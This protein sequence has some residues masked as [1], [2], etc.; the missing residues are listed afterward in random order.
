MTERENYQ[1]SGIRENSAEMFRAGA[2]RPLGKYG[3]DCG[4][5]QA[6][7]QKKKQVRIIPD[8]GLLSE[9]GLSPSTVWQTAGAFIPG[10]KILLCFLNRIPKP[11]EKVLSQLE[12]LQQRPAG[13]RKANM[14]YDLELDEYAENLISETF[15]S[16]SSEQRLDLAALLTNKSFIHRSLS[17][18]PGSIK[19]LNQVIEIYES[20][21]METNPPD[22]RQ[23]LAGRSGVKESCTTKS[24]ITPRQQDLYK[25]AVAIYEELIR[26]DRDQ[27][28][29]PALARTWT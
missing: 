6:I 24:E 27:A 15:K 10:G 25:K 5:A 23:N 18:F 19:V 20:L 22:I 29:I 14:L 3:G 11:S 9:D 1:Q 8:K 12:K 13:S 4:T 17:D 26:K 2:G 7:I 16:V 28:I 21:M